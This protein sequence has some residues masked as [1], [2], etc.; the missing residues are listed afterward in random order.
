MRSHDEFRIKILFVRCIGH[1][2]S[3]K[4]SNR[5]TMNRTWS[6]QKAN[7]ALKNRRFAKFLKNYLSY[8]HWVKHG[9]EWIGLEWNGMEWNWNGM[10]WNGMEWIGMEWNGILS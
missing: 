1:F 4:K 10:E 6:N 7:P 9:M 3:I 5:K 8:R 2:Q